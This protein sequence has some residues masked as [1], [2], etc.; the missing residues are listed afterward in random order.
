MSDQKPMWTRCLGGFSVMWVTFDFSSKKEGFFAQKR[1]NLAQ[2]WHFWSIWARPCRLIR[3]PDGWSVCSC[4]TQAVSRKTPIYFMLSFTVRQ[5]FRV[6]PGWVIDPTTKKYLIFMH[7]CIFPP[8]LWLIR[9]LWWWWWCQCVRRGDD[10]TLSPWIRR[11]QPEP[12][13]GGE[14]Q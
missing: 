11:S 7:I 9:C 2:N 10:Q 8:P 6:G 1:P 3:C 5:I 4:G 12:P 14:D 13:A